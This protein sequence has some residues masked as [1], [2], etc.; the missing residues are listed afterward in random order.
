LEGQR[1]RISSPTTKKNK[2]WIFFG[3]TF[4]HRPACRPCDLCPRT[5]RPFPK[6]RNAHPAP[7]TARSRPR[8]RR[9]K[10]TIIARARPHLCAPA[11]AA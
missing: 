7:V 2:A 6:E 5:P 11:A 3:A 8:R 1:T 9:H 4:V 10:R